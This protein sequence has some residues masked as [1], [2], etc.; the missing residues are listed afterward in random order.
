ML[1]SVER[2]NG[3][4]GH[5]WQERKAGNGRGPKVCGGNVHGPEDVME[6]KSWKQVR[7]KEHDNEKERER[8]L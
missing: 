8:T 2:E 6:T 4:T 3:K 5:G 7:P 1:M